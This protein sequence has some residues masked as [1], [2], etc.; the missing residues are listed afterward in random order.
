MQSESHLSWLL[1]IGPTILLCLCVIAFTAGF[2][3]NPW[4]HYISLGNSLHLG[5]WNRGVDSR[6]VVFNDSHYGPYRGSIIT[7]QDSATPLRTEFGDTCG[8]Y[9]RHFE[10]TGS[11]LWT[12]MVSIWYPIIG[13]AI[14][15][16]ALHRR[17]IYGLANSL[18]RKR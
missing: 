9:F 6:V 10:W 7:L 5:V 14:L 1:R 2:V 8:I 15:S 16:F 3:T 4:R 12:L 17:H 11:S 18:L 13:L